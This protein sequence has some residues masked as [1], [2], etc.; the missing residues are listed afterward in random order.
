MILCFCPTRA[1]VLVVENDRFEIFVLSRFLGSK[2][3]ESDLS[4][5]WQRFDTLHRPYGATRPGTL[6]PGVIQGGREDMHTNA[7]SAW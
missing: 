5:W 7:M 2:T 3:N 4:R 1:S 6:T